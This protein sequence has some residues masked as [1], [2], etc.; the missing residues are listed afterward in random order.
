[1]RTTVLIH[2]LILVAIHKILDSL[3]VLHEFTKMT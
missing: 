3:S 2:A 1:M